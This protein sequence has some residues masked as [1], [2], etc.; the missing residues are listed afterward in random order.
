[1]NRLL[2]VPGALLPGALLLGALLLGACGLNLGGPSDIPMTTVAVHADPGATPAAVGGALEA[3]GARAAFVASGGDV[4]WFA[5]VSA[6]SGLQVSGPATMGDLRLAFLAPEPVGD[7][8]L[9]LRY[10][11]GAFTLHDALYEIE[12]NRL[13]DMMAF[14]LTDAAEVR[15]A[16]GALLQ[17]VATDVA[18]AAAVAMAVAVPSAAVGDSVARMLAPAYSDARRCEPGLAPPADGAH[19][20]LFYGPVARMYCADAEI[21]E[22]AVGAWVRADLVMGRR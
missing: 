1:M 13:L 4:G 5:E 8:T 16:I 2:R 6:A 15:P 18:N 12:E 20:R 14:R 9:Q 17:Y 21:E 10:E 22:S 7:T 19:L 3:A 11:G